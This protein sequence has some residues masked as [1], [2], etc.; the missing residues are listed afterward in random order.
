MTGIP[1]LVS[2]V[3][4]ILNGR[5]A[6]FVP[7]FLLIVAL[8]TESVPL[9]RRMELLEPKMKFESKELA[10]TCLVSVP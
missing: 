4:L 7:P 6:L 1:P 3:S 9:P 2:G 8:R 5:L 10:D